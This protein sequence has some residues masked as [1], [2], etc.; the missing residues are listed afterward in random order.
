MDTNNE[1]KIPIGITISFCNNIAMDYGYFV[2]LSELF[3]ILLCLPL[4]LRSLWA[5]SLYILFSHIG[6]VIIWDQSI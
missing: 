5:L 6:Y 2:Y 3:V 4:F 1:V